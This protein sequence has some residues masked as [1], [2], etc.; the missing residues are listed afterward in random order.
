MVEI[1]DPFESPRT[2]WQ[3]ILAAWALQSGAFQTVEAHPQGGALAL[4]VLMLA[5]VS[6][7]LGQSVV[8]FINRVNPLR[9]VLCLLVGALVFA[10]GVWFWV[11]SVWLIAT[12]ILG[13]KQSLPGVLRAVSLAHAPLL[14]GVF[15]LLP[16]L[17]TFVYRLLYVW[18]LLAILT[19]LMATF[20]LNF[21]QALEC[22]VLGWLFVEG[23][24][25]FAE[26]PVRAFLDWIWRITTGKP[27]R[28]SVEELTRSAIQRA[29]RFPHG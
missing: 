5:G 22:G 26:Q 29:R 11:G 10:I 8:L 28:I 18:T 7:T 25:H 9:F 17:G 1:P 24:E 14:F 12:L 16:Y 2:L 20:Q 15:V 21:W 3:L 23:L 19:A 27:T 13:Y 4:T 6:L